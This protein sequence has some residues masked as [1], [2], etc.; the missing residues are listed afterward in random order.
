MGRGPSNN[1]SEFQFDDGEY[2]YSVWDKSIAGLI[3]DNKI[4]YQNV[5]IS[6]TKL[7][8]CGYYKNKNG[9]IYDVTS[10]FF[11]KLPFWGWGVYESLIY[12]NEFISDRLKRLRKEKL[13]KD[14]RKLHEKEA[15]T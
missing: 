10:D 13:I 12:N 1:L 9:I 3:K 15:K 7:A 11:I 2:V 8:K 14:L 6:L 4:I 5:E